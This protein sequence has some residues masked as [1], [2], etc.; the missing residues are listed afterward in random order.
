VELNNSEN[1]EFKVFH[2]SV[3]D[4]EELVSQMNDQAMLLVK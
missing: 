4:L 1:L 3:V 2:P